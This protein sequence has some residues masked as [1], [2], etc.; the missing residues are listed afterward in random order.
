MSKSIKPRVFAAIRLWLRPFV[1][2]L[3]S[4][5]VTWKEFA[6][7]S[8]AAYVDMAGK[9]YGIQGRPANA[10]RVAI[11]TGLS[12]REVKK[13]RDALKVTNP[14][15]SDKTNMAS[16]V[17]AAWH[18]DPDFLDKRRKPLK[19]TFQ[20]SKPNFSE[21]LKRYAG[22]IPAVAMLKELKNVGAIEETK[23]GK[24][25]VVTRYYMPAQVDPESILRAGEVLHDFG[26]TVV[27][28]LTRDADTVSRF[29]G[30]A[31]NKRVNARSLKAFE[32]LVERRGESFLY[33]IDDW[34]SAREVSEE[35]THKKS[36]R[37][38]VGV[39]IIKDTVTK[40]RKS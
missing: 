35:D 31:S 15:V 28:N 3:L 22:D 30:R 6:E 23:D 17:L 11:L 13:Q 16:R 36:V 39:Y 9:D 12:R 38:G 26:A 24:L 27:H 8:K 19:L 37:V 7:M 29:E 14:E 10:S 5:G 25:N 34:L 32:A 21:L 1:R 18:Q 33:A 20:G 4:T 40:G 2:F